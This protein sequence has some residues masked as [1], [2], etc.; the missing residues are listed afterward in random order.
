MDH[1]LFIHSSLGHLGCFHFLATVNSAAMNIC[2][3]V[4]VWTDGFISLGL[5]LGV[6]LLDPIE[7]LF[8]LFFKHF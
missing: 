7:I 5:Y 1:I 4:L 2:V 3:Q 8:K 6:E